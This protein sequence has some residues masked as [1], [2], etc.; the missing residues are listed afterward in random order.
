MNSRRAKTE[1]EE[2]CVLV[3]FVVKVENVILCRIESKI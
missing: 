3:C 1:V 2:F